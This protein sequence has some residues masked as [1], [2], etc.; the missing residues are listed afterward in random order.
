M[1]VRPARLIQVAGSVV[2]I[3]TFL[4]LFSNDDDIVIPQGGKVMKNIKSFISTDDHKKW[5]PFGLGLT[6]DQEMR[7]NI[8]FKAEWVVNF[9]NVII[10]MNN[11]D[12][13]D[14]SLIVDYE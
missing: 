8:I 10:I 7:E 14:R 1:R 13:L 3:L 12:G 6:S 2:V 11:L 5:D 9:Q 4:A